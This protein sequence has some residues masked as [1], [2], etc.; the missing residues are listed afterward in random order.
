[1]C[2]CCTLACSFYSEHIHLLSPLSSLKV[3]FISYS[4]NLIIPIITKICLSSGM[5]DE[6]QETQGGHS[7]TAYNDLKLKAR[8]A[9]V[10]RNKLIKRTQSTLLCHYELNSAEIYLR[11]R[12]IIQQT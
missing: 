10:V 9:C 8:L 11:E 5:H 12:D 4:V 6:I 7:N 3:D 2:V 1:M